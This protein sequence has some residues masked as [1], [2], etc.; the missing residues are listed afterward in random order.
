MKP[1]IKI[2]EFFANM[3]IKT[4]KGLLGGLG[5]LIVFAVA[6]AFLL[7]GKA[8]TSSYS[9]LFSSLNEQEASEVMA[10]LQT[11]GVDY[12]Y[13]PDGSIAVPAEIVDKTRATM[14]VEGFPRNGFTYETYL[15]NSNLMS[16]ET[17]KKSLQVYDMQDRLQAT[18]RLLDGVKDAIVQISPGESKKYVLDNTEPSKPTASVMVIMRDGSAPSNEQVAGIQRLVAKSINGMETGDVAVIDGNGIDVSVKRNDSGTLASDEKMEFEEKTQL[19]VENNILHVLGDM[20]GRNNVRV[21]VK[22]T[23][24]VSKQ[25]S[26]ES[27]YTAPNTQNNSGYI[28][29]Q[30]LYNEGESAAGTGGV[31]GADTN[32]NLPQ[33]D[34]QAGAGQ[35]TYSGSSDTEYALN[36]KKIQSQN[37]SASIT[38]LTVAVSINTANLGID[39]NE[40][41]RLIGNASG[42]NSTLQADKIVVV[43]SEWPTAKLVEEVPPDIE[44]VT[45]PNKI[46]GIPLS[47]PLLIGIGVGVLLLLVLL[48]IIMIVK[49]SKKR[50]AAELA[51]MMEQRATPEEEAIAELSKHRVPTLSVEE[52]RGKEIK[53]NI[54]DFTRDNPEISAQ[55]LKNWLRGGESDA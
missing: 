49:R 28:E 24:D 40:L 23:A 32:A 15:D 25:V 19:M 29:Q 36:Q 46:T 9:T 14:A 2:K 1:S 37:E 17:D 5:V 53:D 16:T 44:I 52:E 20:Y 54:R 11:N 45:P 42:I 31:P 30:S 43:N 51:R 48:L 21:S 38:D 34:T 50:G 41:L 3:P 18:I 47:L 55:L 27:Q 10:K 13:S 6:V 22:C 33:Y 7:N 39:R 4:K 12:R 35:N 26:E 8:D